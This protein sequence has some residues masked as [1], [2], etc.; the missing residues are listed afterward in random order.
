M[1]ASTKSIIKN[2]EPAD[3][4]SI[5]EFVLMAYEHNK[6]DMTTTMVGTNPEGTI[7]RLISFENGKLE[8]K[9][10]DYNGFS[11]IHFIIPVDIHHQNKS[12]YL[13]IYSRTNYFSIECFEPWHKNTL[14]IITQCDSI[15][16]VIANENNDTCLFYQFENQTMIYDLKNKVTINVEFETR[17][18]IFN[19]SSAFIDVDG[20]LVPELVLF[21]RENNE[22]FISIY[23]KIN[24]TY[25]K[26]CEINISKYSDL[27]GP[28]VFGDF[29]VSGGCDIAFVSQDKDGY[30]LN[31]LL[32]KRTRVKDKTV[33][34]KKH[35]NHD[36][37]TKKEKDFYDTDTNFKRFLLKDPHQENLKFVP[38]LKGEKTM[39]N[40][41]CG[42]LVVDINLDSYPDIL[43]AG[44]VG[45]KPYI[46]ILENLYGTT[47]S[48]DLLFTPH[49]YPIPYKPT[50]HKNKAGIIVADPIPTIISVSIADILNEDEEFLIINYEKNNNYHIQCIRNNTSK[51]FYKISVTTKY[52]GKN[53]KD[54]QKI[55]PG[56][57]YKYFIDENDVT[58]IGHQFTQSS[59][60]HLQAPFLTLGLGPVNFL[61]D[62]FYIG[63]PKQSGIDAISV[64]KTKIIPNSIVVFKPN[65]RG[66][67]AVELYLRFKDYFLNI[68]L[69]LLLVLIVNLIIVFYGYKKE[70]RK[71]RQNRK[72][73]SHFFNF[74]AL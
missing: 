50:T 35:L 33:K 36:N 29:D 25:K 21:V 66:Y 55:V 57:G 12:S 2:L 41:S 48:V 20:D 26:T 67:V 24:K 16:L 45:D 3:E 7:I 47:N 63:G 17:K 28:F 71:E 59:F 69:V 40:I 58:R 8:P 13:L 5:S 10:E 70:V 54:E 19:H 43:I 23:S 14:E 32:N 15:P 44:K 61:I 49:L 60:L 51:D 27:L 72:L 39:K 9:I 46:C 1:T 73:E 64:V 53:F 68:F 62:K 42:V 6:D 74:S 22:N 4:I 18:L 31:V 65:D 34:N 11:S 37:H 56:I 30:Y 38:F 52:L